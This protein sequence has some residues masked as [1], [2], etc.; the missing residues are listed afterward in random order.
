M[1]DATCTSHLLLLASTIAT[2]PV[3]GVG[4]TTLTRR[5]VPSYIRMRNW[6]I[7]IVRIGSASPT[8]CAGA[9]T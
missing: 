8:E 4:E 6:T 3:L 1:D 9:R 7:G 5:L 2:G